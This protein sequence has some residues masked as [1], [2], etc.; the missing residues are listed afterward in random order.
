MGGGVS[1][2]TF[3]VPHGGWWCHRYR[4]SHG[5][6]ADTPS[7]TSTLYSYTHLPNLVPYAISDSLMVRCIDLYWYKYPFVMSHT[8]H[9]HQSEEGRRSWVWIPAYQQN[10]LFVVW[11]CSYCSFGFGLLLYLSLNICA[12]RLLKGLW[13]LKGSL[14][15]K[16]I[17]YLHTFPYASDI[18]T[19]SDSLMVRYIDLYWYTLLSWVTLD[20]QSNALLF[21]FFPQYLT[22]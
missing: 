2:K 10:L 3:L 13:E 15:R 12:F 16:Q 11:C 1:E 19:L 5:G 8:L 18:S 4:N 14:W 6:G 22:V 20:F 9:F 21:K 7:S 17:L